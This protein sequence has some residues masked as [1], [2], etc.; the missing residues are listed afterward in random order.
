[1]QDDNYQVHGP[2]ELEQIGRF[3]AYDPLRI[4]RTKHWCASCGIE[5]WF[6]PTYVDAVLLLGKQLCMQLHDHD[7]CCPN[8]PPCTQANLTDILNGSVLSTI[9]NAGKEWPP[10][11]TGGCH[12]D[13]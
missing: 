13:C 12:R 11:G 10:R 8:P 5:L 7:C 9:T 4:I 6:S 1:M 2:P 3:T